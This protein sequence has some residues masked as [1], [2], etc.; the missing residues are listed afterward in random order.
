LIGIQIK[1]VSQ[2]TAAG[3]AASQSPC[4]SGPARD[5]GVVSCRSGASFDSQIKIESVST[6]LAADRAA[7]QLHCRSG[8]V[9]DRGAAFC[10]SGAS[11]DSQIKIESVST[12]LSADRAALKLHCRSGLARDRGAASCRSGASFDSQIKIE[13][14]S[15]RLAADR[16]ALKLHCRSGLARDRG[17]ACCRSGAWFEIPIRVQSVSYR[18]SAGPS[19]FSLFRQREVTRRKETPLS[20]RHCCAMSVPCVARNPAAGANSRIHAL[21]QGRLSPPAS[22]ATRR[23]RRDP[24]VKGASPLWWNV[25]LWFYGCAARMADHWGP[26]PSAGGLRCRPAG[27]STRMCER[28]PSAGCAVGAPSSQMV[29]RLGICWQRN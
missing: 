13:S 26:C 5:R 29:L 20:R 9:R 3:R 7:L 12:R 24:T 6:R 1:G 15:T 8:L 10:R 23:C 16:A 2:R 28:S 4:R 11:F 27:A 14:V 19:H 25:A 17:V 18:L 22:C 21:E